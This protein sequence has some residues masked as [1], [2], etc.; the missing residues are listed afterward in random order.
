MGIYT[1]SLMVETMPVTLPKLCLHVAIS[2]PAENPFKEMRFVVLHNDSTLAEVSVSEDEL[3]QAT[4]PA[5]DTDINQHQLRQKLSFNFVFSPLV[6]TEPGKITLR[7]YT[8]SG[9]LRGPSLRLD[10]A[11]DNTVFP[12]G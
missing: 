1:G 4:P 5:P 2:T 9:E 11:P 12:A 7:A 8:E 10:L 6:L 3:T